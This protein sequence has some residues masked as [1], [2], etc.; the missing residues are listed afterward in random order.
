MFERP[1]DGFDHR[2]GIATCAEVGEHDTDY[3][4]GYTCNAWQAGARLR[5]VVGD[6]LGRALEQPIGERGVEDAL[7]GDVTADVHQCD[8]DRIFAQC[9]HVERHAQR[10]FDAVAMRHHRAGTLRIEA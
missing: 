6:H 9:G 4:I 5:Q 1:D 3:V 7:I 8:T 2:V 10:F